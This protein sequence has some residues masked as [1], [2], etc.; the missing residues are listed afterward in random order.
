MALTK[1]FKA[2]NRRARRR[3]KQTPPATAARYDRKSGRVVISLGSGLDLMVSPQSVEGLENAAPAQLSVIEVSP[4]GFGLY[5]P[6]LDAD[7]YLPALLEGVLGSKKWMASRLGSL[8]GGKTSLA[9]KR[10]ARANGKLG[11]RPTK[12]AV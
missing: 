7:V 2:A 5:F 6:K 11:G 12:S 1:E 10:A 9:K 4:S 8:G 3:L